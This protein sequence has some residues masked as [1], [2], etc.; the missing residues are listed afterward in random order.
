MDDLKRQP[1][2]GIFGTAGLILG[3]LALV[4]AVFHFFGGPFAPQDAVGVTLGEIAAE[5]GKAALRDLVGLG[6]PTPVPS[7]WD[8]DRILW[9][10]TAVTGAFAVVLA[11]IA[12]VRHEPRRIVIGG[13]ALG[14]AAITF[15]FAAVI[16]MTLLAILV[17][18]IILDS[19]GLG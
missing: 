7:P 3:G 19:L 9:T 4:L 11:V 10:G 16:V 2:A 15:Q 13:A 14:A 18:G 12:L 1:T 5:A 6:Q 17:I 8:I